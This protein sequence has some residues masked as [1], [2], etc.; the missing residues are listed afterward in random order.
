[1]KRILLINAHPSPSTLCSELANAFALGAMQ[2]SRAEL[3]QLTL[4]EMAFDPILHQGYQGTTP[5]EPDL[6]RAQADILWA[7]H[8]VFVYPNWWGSMPALLKGF[9]DRPLLPG[10]AFK[11]RQGSPLWDKLLAGRT[12]QLLVTM[13]TPGWYYRWVWHRPGHQQM[14]HAILGYCGIKTTGIT[15]FAPVHGATTAQRQAW[16]EKARRLGVRTA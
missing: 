7:Q 1:M 4:R 16:I 3:R 11:Y 6:Q 10:F 15:E 12:A 9:F 2:T 5:L 8:L 13:D 14:R